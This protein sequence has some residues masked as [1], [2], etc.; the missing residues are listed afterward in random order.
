MRTALLVLP[1]LLLAAHPSGAQEALPSHRLTTPA[2]ASGAPERCSEDIGLRALL[3]ATLFAEKRLSGDGSN[4]CA[5]CHLPELDFSDGKQR[6]IGVNGEPLRR[7]SLV[8]VGHAASLFWDGRAATLEAQIEAVLESPEEMA[9]S[10][11]RAAR[12]LAGDPFPAHSLPQH[13]QRRR[14][15]RAA[16]RASPAPSL[17]PASRRP[18]SRS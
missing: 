2:P 9:S 11:A 14:P 17:A 10:P 12:A 6:A 16:T 5:T 18:R 13:R 3:G 4:A 15:E 7:P 1:L 8:N